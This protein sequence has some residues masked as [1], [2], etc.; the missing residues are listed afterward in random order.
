MRN[1]QDYS[2]IS[3]RAVLPIMCDGWHFL[4]RGKHLHG[5]IISQ[6]REV[7]A[8][9]TFTAS[10]L[11][12]EVPVQSQESEISYMC[13]RG[14][15]F[16]FIYDFDIWLLN[17]SDSVILFIFHF[18]L[19]IYIIVRYATHLRLSM[20]S[21]FCQWGGIQQS[22]HIYL[23]STQ[24]TTHTTSVNVERITYIWLLNK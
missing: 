24:Y 22:R 12:I 2:D 20:W 14:T 13:V 9:R 17:C 16:I 19:D 15:D 4:S 6:R 18:M 11:F 1:V 23:S 3:H 7:W 8:H 21:L 5:H 10:P